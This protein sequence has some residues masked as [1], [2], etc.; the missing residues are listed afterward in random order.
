MWL[1]KGGRQ[2]GAL[3]KT[4]R[5]EGK[6]FVLK[7]RRRLVISRT[8][9]ACGFYQ[10]VSFIY[11]SC[12]LGNSPCSKQLRI[13]RIITFKKYFPFHMGWDVTD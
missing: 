1:S 12:A 9:H 6:P 4:A 13:L 10:Y 5:E 7:V 3:K 11:Q 2:G 8:K